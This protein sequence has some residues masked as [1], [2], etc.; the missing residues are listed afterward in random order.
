MDDLL[1]RTCR[2]WTASRDAVAA[3]ISVFEKVRDIHY[4][5]ELDLIHHHDF[6]RILTLNRGSC[7]PKHF[8]LC[9]MYQRLGVEV[10]FAAFPFRW[11]EV[12]LDY[13]PALLRLARR[14]PTSYHL[15]CRA[16]LEGR[17]I[18]VDATL[19]PG[20]QELG[21]PVNLTWDGVSDTLLPMN[22]CGREELYHP[23]EAAYVQVRGDPD[24]LA[25]YEGLNG[26]LEEM[27]GLSGLK[28]A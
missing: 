10:L 22:P 8:L 12:E 23:S 14:L 4:A 18:L 3:R 27:R 21:L 13:P 20:M 25:F 11:D 9:D 24:S 19:D 2:E 15:A 17:S 7:T 5:I 28:P 6:A 26:W 16:Q 1:E